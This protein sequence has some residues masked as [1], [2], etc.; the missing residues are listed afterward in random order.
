L[1]KRDVVAEARANKSVSGKFLWLEFNRQKLWNNTIA[2]DRAREDF[3]GDLIV[4]YVT[5]RIVDNT[6]TIS[7]PLYVR[8]PNAKPNAQGYRAMTSIQRSQQDALAVV[9]AEIDRCRWAIE[10]GRNIASVL[11]QKF[12]GL[13]E[14]FETLLREIVETRHLLEKAA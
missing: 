7:A 14:R 8:D 3:A 4:R 5:M 12:P 13:V 11:D 10:R 6:I 2:A 1:R 9:L